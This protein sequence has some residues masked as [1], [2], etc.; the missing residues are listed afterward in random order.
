MNV[1]HTTETLAGR[2]SEADELARSVR[3]TAIDALSRAQ[4]IADDDGS[5]LAL[6]DELRSIV[7]GLA[8]LSAK[9]GSLSAE[10]GDPARAV[11]LLHEL[12][13]RVSGMPPANGD[14]L[15]RPRVYVHRDTGA[16]VAVFPGSGGGMPE[17]R[18]SALYSRPQAPRRPGEFI[19]PML[20]LDSAMSSLAPVGGSL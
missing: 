1:I 17:Q 16:V 20:E 6:M 11:Q 14:E 5:P 12:A 18:P 10:L 2:A 13:A 4:S 15:V 3:Q 9:V 19:G 7:T 8:N